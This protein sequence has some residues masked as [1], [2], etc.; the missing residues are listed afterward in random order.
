MV[1]SLSPTMH[2]ARMM[3]DALAKQMEEEQQ[4]MVSRIEKQKQYAKL[5]LAEVCYFVT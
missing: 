1:G 2:S 4:Q 3:A 5:R